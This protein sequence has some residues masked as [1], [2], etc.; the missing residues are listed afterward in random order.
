MQNN[1]GQFHGGSYKTEH[2]DTNSMLYV[3][4]QPEAKLHA[5]PGSMVA[6]SPQV[7]LKGKSKFSLKKMF[8]GGQMAMSTFT[9]PGEV[10]LAPPIW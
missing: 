8:I 1:V 10:L 6:M 7:Q 9:G 5:L 3:M 2:R 4:L